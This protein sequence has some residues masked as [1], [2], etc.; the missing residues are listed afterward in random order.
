MKKIL[1]L[2]MACGIINNTLASTN[3]G[4][5]TQDQLVEIL[6][7]LELARAIMYY[8]D[9]NNLRKQADI[10]FQEQVQLICEDH[11]IDTA[12][13]QK[14]YIDYLNH[15]TRLEALYNQVIGKLEELL[16]T[17]Y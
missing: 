6:V 8:D 14:S 15:P 16:K 11:F 1:A 3:S 10:L 5:L 4:T 7:D 2:I 17:S 13:F 9:N 12:T